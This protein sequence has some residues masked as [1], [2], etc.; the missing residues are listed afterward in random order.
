MTLIVGQICDENGNDIPPDTPPP[1]RNSDQGPDIWTP[2]N[3]RLEFE[4]ADF[5]YRRNQMSAGDINFILGLW[6]ASLATHNDKPPFSNANDMYE[7]IDSTPLGDIPWESV[8]LQYNGAQPVD[9]IPSWMKA[10]HDVWFRNPRALVHNIISNPDFESG[11]DYVPFQERTA[12]GV[13]RFC[14]FMSSNWPWKQAVS[15]RYCLLF[16]VNCRLR[17]LGHYCR[18]GL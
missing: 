17:C 10:E 2:Y 11:F 15:S 5:L 9:N 12:D 18:E 6:A 1:P 14:D 16:T 3:S 13:H 4:V 7:T 8:T